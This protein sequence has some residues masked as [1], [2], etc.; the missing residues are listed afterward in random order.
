MSPT[1]TTSE[2]VPPADPVPKLP[3]ALYRIFI[4]A[5]PVGIWAMDRNHRTT[6]VNPR[7]AQMLACPP[8]EVIGQPVE[9]F[10][11]A[12][13]LPA[14]KER[15]ARRH[16]GESASYEHRFRRKDGSELWTIVS[17]NPLLTADGRFDGSFAMF[18]DITDRKRAEEER[19]VIDDLLNLAPAAIVVHDLSGRFLYANARALEMHGYSR[20]EFMALRLQD[21][22]TPDCARLIE[23]KIT[24]LKTGAELTFEVRHRRK[25]GSEFP[26][27]AHAR[28][29]RWGDRE[30]VLS[31]A[32]DITERQSAARALEQSEERFRQIVER[33]SD[34]FYRQNLTTGQF[35]YVS[36]K[37]A[38]VLGYTPDE[39]MALTIDQQ[40][41]AVHPDDLPAL[42]S[43]RSDLIEAADSGLD[44]IEREFRLRTKQGEY[45]WIHGNYTLLRDDRKQPRS[46]LGSLHDVTEHRLAEKALREARDK[47]QR[48]FTEMGHGFALHQLI[49]DETGA[50]VDYVTF[51]VNR[52]YEQLMGV[53]ASAVVGHRA[54][55]FL[56]E[57]E[58]RQWLAVFAKVATEG[59]DARYE[60][61]SPANNRHFSGYAYSTRKDQFAVVFEDV[62]ERVRVEESLRK[63]ERAYREL[64]EG[65]PDVVIRFDREGRHLF[66]SANVTRVA[67]IPPESFIGKTHRELGFPEANCRSWEEAIRN[68]VDSGAPLETEFTFSAGQVPAVFNWRLVPE[69][70]ASGHVTSIL[71]I[72]RDITAHRKAEQDYQTLFREMLDGVALHEIICDAKGAPVNYRFLAVNPAF[73]RM[74]GLKAA[75]IVGKSVLDVMPGTEPYWIETYGQVALTG[76]PVFFVNYAADLRKHFEVKA[77]RP[78]ANQFVCIFT[79][80]TERLESER[81]RERLQEQLLQSQKMESIGRLAG[82]VAHDFNNQLACIMGFA[83]LLATSLRDDQLRHY[84]QNIV[85]ASTRA[86]Q[87]TRQLLAFARKGKYVSVPVD[88]HAIIAEVI[89]LLHRGLDKRIDVRTRLDAV[90]AGALGDPSQLQNAVLNLA[91]NAADAMPS[92]GVLTIATALVDLAGDAAPLD[93]APGR[94]VRLAVSDTGVGMTPETQR[95]LFEPFYTTKEQGKGTG[96][97]LAAVYGAVRNHRGGITVTSEPGKGSTFTLF[98]PLHVGSPAPEP[99]PSDLPAPGKAH[100][101]IVDDDPLVAASAA[102]M[103]R[104][105]GY[106]VTVRHSGLDALAFYREN[107]RTVDLV[108]LDM[109][110]PGMDG[111]AAF[112]ALRAVNPDLKA[113]LTSGYGVDGE[114]QRILDSGVRGFVPK[115]YHLDELIAALRAVGL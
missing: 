29:T 18:T 11:F 45:R 102:E 86:S 71:S 14:H 103:L 80:I 85:T 35:E 24:R 72:S 48:L 39:L 99:K 91:I 25:D 30:V 56:P 98:L 63:S 93:V 7:M 96:L 44:H 37:A 62:S 54:S 61:Y 49:F 34:L 51:E 55:E 97:G 105:V 6:F 38:E 107:A 82:G 4:Q 47:Y 109:V 74:T 75:D 53:P 28:M 76:K 110:M 43:F 111:Q 95:H 9:R 27:L 84:A 58:L 65:I 114:A 13:D 31:V 60:V 88:L 101:L 79:D 115:P 73:E 8:S 32:R 66:V 40:F 106:T 22:D 104:S 83:D 2:N 81:E 3:D 78:A 15:M 87:L 16:A 36:P 19:R 89:E 90:P 17:A 100:I 64:V 57:T 21:L 108:L 67:G 33:A 70:D 59:S 41:A 50:P 112:L 12:E 113:L 26:L 5:A 42:K 52:G 94:Y 92:G 10:M 23:D 77:F 1:R 68:V 69:R 20:Q 46:V